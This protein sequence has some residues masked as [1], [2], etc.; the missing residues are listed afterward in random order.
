METQE[1][2]FEL[3]IPL[4]QTQEEPEQYS[5]IPDP[6]SLGGKVIGGTVKVVGKILGSI[7]D[8]IKP[9]ERSDEE[10]SNENLE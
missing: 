1:V 10:N 9:E 6:I 7:I 4:E 8:V 2:H 5:E 3:E